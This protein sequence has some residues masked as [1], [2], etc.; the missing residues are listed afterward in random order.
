ML[1]AALLATLVIA[2]LGYGAIRWLD[3]DAGRAFV[4]RQLPLYKPASGLTVRAGRI[5]GSIFGAATIHDLVIGDPAGTLATARVVE[6]DWRPLDLLANLL[7]LRRLAAPEVRLLRRP[8]LR[9]S[10]SDRVLPDI[11][12]ALGQLRIDRLVLEAPVAGERRILGLG[13]SADIRKGRALVRLAALTLA[14]A[15]CAAGG[16]TVRLTLDSEPDRDRFDIDALVQGPKGGAI[17]ALVGI[18][19]GI[20]L[21]LTGD[22]SWTVWRGS[23]MARLDGAPAADLAVTARDGLFTAAG[24]L[25]PA[26]LLASAAARLLGP[27]TRLDATARLADRRATLSISA[28]SP[29]LTASARGIADFGSE[30]FENMAIAARLLRPVAVAPKFAAQ[31]LRLAARLA[32]SFARPIA[33]WR[34]TAAH[35]GWG[36]TQATAVMASGIAQPGAPL[37]VALRAARITGLGADFDPLLTGVRIDGPIAIADGRITSDRLAFSSDRLAG[38]ATASVVPDGA[39]RFAVK[40][41][42]PGYALAGVGVADVG[43]DLAIVAAPAGVSASGPVRIVAR[44][45]DVPAAARLLAGLPVLTAEIALAPDN[46]LAFRNARLVA[47]GLTFTASGRR[48]ADGRLDLAGSGV[49]RDYGPLGLTL[50][51]RAEAPTIGLTLARPGLSL[52]LADVRADIAPDAGK[53]RFAVTAGSTYG[54]IAARGLVDPGTPLAVDLAALTVA[55]VTGSGRVVQG[56]DNLFSGVLRATGRGLDGTATLAAAGGVQ[57]IDVAATARDATLAL[58][59]PVTIVSGSLKLAVLLPA[60]G[61]SARGS[62]TA[63]GVDRDGSRIDTASGDIAYADGRGSVT[64]RVA[65]QSGVPFQLA[66]SIGLAPERI[67][68]AADGTLD[69][70]RVA[71]SAPAVLTRAGAAWTLA[72]VTLTS[73]DGSATVSGSFSDHSTVHARLDRLSLALLGIYTPN[74]DFS[75]RVSGNVDIAVTPDGIPTGNASLRVASL[76]RAGIATSSLPID[77]GLNANLGPGGIVARAVIVRGTAVL[78]RA[79]ARLAVPPGAAPLTDRLLLAPITGQVRFAGPAQALWGLS[80][81]EALDVRGPLAVDTALGGTLGDPRL[82][83]TL[84]ARGARAELTVLG[85]VVDQVALDGR[86]TGARLE[87][88]RFAG[89]VGS[90]GSIAGSGGID[91]SAERAFPI[92]I[93]LQLKNAQLLKRDDATGTASGS[94]RIATDEYGG[95]VSGRLTVDRALYRLGRTAAAEVPVL[96]VREVNTQVLGRRVSRYAAPTRWLLDLAVK[97]DRRLNVSGMGLEAEWQA[98]VRVRGGATTPE[99]FGRVQLVRGDY[100]FAGKRFNL[101][102]G[103]LRFQGGYPADPLIDVSATTTQNGFTAQLDVDG[104]AL[105]PQIAFSSLPSLPEDEVLS[106]VLFGSTVTD[107]SAPEAVQLAAALASLRGGSGGGLNPINLVRKGLGIDRLRILPADT[108][109]GRKTAVAAGQYIGRSVYVELATDASGYTATNIEVSL[110]RSLSIL[111]ELATLGGQSVNLRWKRDY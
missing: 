105:R 31:D 60:A 94:V 95:V 102:K 4:V 27:V 33:E 110:T 16:D 65:G 28:T 66:T 99:I 72:P 34:L 56:D 67:T 23:L 63:A 47:P 8:A 68:I 89:R 58:A 20:D 98:D 44:R 61:P 19:R 101:T 109:K 81:L 59:T 6:V 39:S 90:N 5:D 52:G 83:G 35:L 92:D 55:G 111:S 85:A 15:G 25:R 32:G 17:A 84:A 37:P 106:R 45:I 93:R 77:V 22:G 30:R 26:P 82:T 18:D 53:W 42:L 69:G 11:D 46:S 48:L 43:V 64:A 49:S 100:D 79:Q 12:I 62:F 71:L 80:G 54:P 107:L 36:A 70:R 10:A 13:G 87:L 73:A 78:G 1:S 96:Q 97:G 38:T 104:T 76:A 9:P 14:A 57:R 7:T 51:G 91:L 103:D 50:A 21:K 74:L 41:S 3:S 40:G 88:T 75:G 29:A 2:A 24:D 86:F 108:T